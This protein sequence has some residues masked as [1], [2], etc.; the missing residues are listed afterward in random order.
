V[1]LFASDPHCRTLVDGGQKLLAKVKSE[2]EVK[3]E[4]GDGRS[5]V[6][7]TMSSKAQQLLDKFD[8]AFRGLMKSQLDEI[9]RALQQT[10]GQPI[11][12]SYAKQVEAQ[13]TTVELLSKATAHHVALLK[14]RH[15]LGKTDALNLIDQLLELS[16]QA[17]EFVNR[18][19]T[20]TISGA[21]SVGKTT[22]M[23]FGIKVTNNY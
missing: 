11:F 19:T 16:N 10:H 7:F 8:E 12:E 4:L 6:E 14:N 15:F 2:S 5:T 18:V 21:T 20:I 22:F 17:M 3:T 1:A 23:H 9:D 13:R